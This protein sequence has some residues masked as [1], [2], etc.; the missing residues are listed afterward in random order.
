MKFAAALV[1]LALMLVP[2]CFCELVVDG[3][4]DEWP[5][6]VCSGSLP[7]AAVREAGDRLI[8]CLVLSSPIS[9]QRNNDLVLV[10]DADA[11][12]E[13]G[14]PLGGVGA[15]VVWH[16]GKRTGEI[17]RAA[18][19][20]KITAYDLGMVTAPTT[21]A[22]AFE[23]SL[24]PEMPEL[25]PLLTAPVLNW[26]VLSK[27]KVAA[28]GSLAW[29]NEPYDAAGGTS[30]PPAGP[31]VRVLS[32][33]VLRNGIVREPALYDRILRALRPDIIALQEVYGAD[34][35]TLAE[36]FGKILGGDWAVT[37]HADLVVASR[38]PLLASRPVLGNLA[39]VVDLTATPIEAPLR[40]LNLH[41]PASRRDRE[42]QWEADAL[43]AFLRDSGQGEDPFAS[44][45]SPL[46]VLGDFNF[47]GDPGQLD[48]LLRGAIVNRERFGAD[49]PPDNDGTDLTD[50]VPRHSSAPEVYTWWAK[51][52]KAP[53]YPG[54]LDFIL[55]SD[56]TLSPSG[57]ILR[58]ESLGSAVLDSLKLERF[59]TSRASDHLPLVID[60]LPSAAAR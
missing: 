50:L 22:S 41:L 58:S 5:D 45:S 29:K 13:T 53:Y 33:N 27:D 56:A 32:Y 19:V 37:A 60:L 6:S 11:D 51:G 3:R 17:H 36:R 7:G 31:A 9:L 18:R 26:A 16:F 12:P 57:F 49:F 8:F 55:Y 15:E 46:V 42:R 10:L 23:V 52:G 25:Y 54:R 38:Y 44:P 21:A 1:L 24:D 43:I 34:T 20:E 40:L 14:R 4:L 47:V 39:V 59:D 28:N 2:P 35:P 48:T 30:P